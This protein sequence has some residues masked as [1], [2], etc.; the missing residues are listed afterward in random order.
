MHDQQLFIDGPDV[1]GLLIVD[2]RRNV[3]RQM[4]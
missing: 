4:A 3:V 2:G 1:S